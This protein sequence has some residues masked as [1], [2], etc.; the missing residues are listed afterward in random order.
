LKDFSP[1]ISGRS[2]EKAKNEPVRVPVRIADRTT[3]MI[4]EKRIGLLFFITGLSVGVLPERVFH[5]S[6]FVSGF[7]KRGVS[8]RYRDSPYPEGDS[9]SKPVFADLCFIPQRMK[10]QMIPIKDSRGR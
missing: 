10:N 9:L 7:L 1:S 3:D 4:T 5:V 2:R 6:A 8:G